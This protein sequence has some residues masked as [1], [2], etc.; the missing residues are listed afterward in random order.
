V[1]SVLSSL[2]FGFDLV[3]RQ[4]F[5]VKEAFFAY[6]ADILLILRYPLFAGGQIF[7]VSLDPFLPVFLQTRIVWRIDA[8]NKGMS[9]HVE[10][11]EFEKEYSCAFVTKHP[12]I[13]PCQIHPSPVLFMFPV[14]GFLRVS[15]A[16]ISLLSKEHP[17]IQLG[18]D[19]FR[20]TYTEVVGPS[21]DN[22]VE[23]LYYCGNV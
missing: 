23:P 16:G 1:V 3:C 20:H 6:F 12:V 19:H 14:P 10:S 2:T 7:D 22:G 5:P 9:S 4:F 8:R 13:F 17:M 21:S 18:E 11:G 15:S